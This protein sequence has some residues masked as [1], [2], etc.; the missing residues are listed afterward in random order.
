MFNIPFIYRGG[1]DGGDPLPLYGTAE[2]IIWLDADQYVYKDYGVTSASFG[3]DVFQWNDLT[4]YRN[5]VTGS[6]T[7]T[8]LYSGITFA[9]S[10]STSVFPYIEFNETNQDYL[11][12]KSSASLQSISSGYTLF[13]VMRKNATGTWSPGD[14]P[15]IE[16][17]DS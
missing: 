6:T 12:V 4:S 17:N 1:F 11:A 8:P 5:N 3:N 13:F 10:G 14:N 15:I 7:E 16:W 2:A 9:P